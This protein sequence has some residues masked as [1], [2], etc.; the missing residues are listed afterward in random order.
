METR[1]VNSL[2]PNITQDN[3]KS[4]SAADAKKAESTATSAAP[5]VATVSGKPVVDVSN[6]ARDLAEAR[7]KALEIAMA[8]PDVREDKVADIK[9]RIAE[10]TYQI[11]SGKIADGILREAIFDHLADS[12]RNS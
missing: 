7:K 5:S 6:K 9:K 2:L 3:I 11:D 8:T 12:D 4:S 10:G 1:K